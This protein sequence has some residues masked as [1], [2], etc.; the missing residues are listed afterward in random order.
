MFSHRD[1]MARLLP[2]R[3]S[4]A[5]QPPGL[6]RSPAQAPLGFDDLVGRIVEV[7]GAGTSAQATWAAGLVAQ[8]QRIGETVAWLL[9]IDGALYPPDLALQGIDVQALAVA[10]LP[11]RPALLK[12][13]DVLLRSGGFGLCVI[14]LD[15]ATQKPTQ[16]ENPKPSPRIRPV[17]DKRFVRGQPTDGQLA[18]LLGLAQKHGAAVVFLTS[19]REPLGSLVSL[20]IEVQRHRRLVGVMG[21]ELDGGGQGDVFAVVTQVTKDKRRGPGPARE[22]AWRGPE[23]MG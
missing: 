17:T 7:T 23:G 21:G 13:A 12:A 1:G 22:E 16:D 8:A 2:L 3:P 9:P 10:R 20:R 14:D 5:F 6:E 4:A 11:D 15:D 19:G 18:R